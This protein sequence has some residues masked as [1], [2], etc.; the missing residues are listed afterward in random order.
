MPLTDTAIKAFKPKDKPY[1]EADGGGLYLEVAPSGGKWWRLK[2]RFDGK[3]KRIS[4][5]TYPT[6]GLKDARERRDEAKK[7][8]S[9]HIDPGEKRKADKVEAEAVAKEQ[10]L[11]FEVVAKEWF[12]TMGTAHRERHRKK[13]LWLLGLLNKHIGGKP[14]A[15]L[16]PA[17]VFAAIRP[18]EA[19]GHICTAHALAQKAGQV[20]RY[21]RRCGYTE[22]NPADSLSEALKPLQTKH[23]ATITDPKE[24]GRLLRAID[25]YEG[26]MSVRY[27]LKIL[28]YVFLRNSELRG[29]E[30]QEI[31]FDRALWTV[32]SSRKDKDDTGMKMRVPHVVPLAR[33]VVELFRDLHMFTGSGPVC[34]PSPQS[35]SQCISDVGLLNALRRM[36]YSKDVMTVHGFRAMFSTLF[37]EQGFDPDHIEKQLAHKEKDKIRDAYNHASY[38]EQRRT[39]MQAWADYLDELRAKA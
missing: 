1:K 39:L 21:A 3:E 30:W 38:L 17:D 19:T 34:F 33:Q 8:L 22:F 20:C 25:E 13:I 4:L 9:N 35:K 15:Q 37:N 23:Y 2:Y 16:K 27:A 6:V 36:G 32:P 24:I 10:A 12:D 28:P 29:A 26:T 18:V 14:I 31:D 11:T 5:G 7:L